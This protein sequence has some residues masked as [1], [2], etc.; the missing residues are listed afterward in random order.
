MFNCFN[1][2]FITITIENLYFI[3]TSLNEKTNNT[4][5]AVF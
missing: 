2:L 1:I 5:K 3:T 4:K